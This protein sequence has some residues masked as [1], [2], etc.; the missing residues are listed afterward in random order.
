MTLGLNSKHHSSS[1]FLRDEVDILIPVRG[2]APW[3]SDCILSILNQTYENFKIYLIID[4]SAPNLEEVIS[5]V[6][7]KNLNKIKILTSPGKGISEALNHGIKNSYNEVIFR[8]DS[9]DTMEQSRIQEQLA[10]LNKFPDVGILGSQAHICNENLTIKSIT[11]LPTKH[12]EIIRTFK[13]SNSMIHPSVAIRRHILFKVGLYDKKADGYE[14]LELWLRLSKLT[15]FAN[16][17]KPLTNYRIHSGQKTFGQ[18]K[19]FIDKFVEAH[20]MNIEW[21]ERKRLLTAKKTLHPVS[22]KKR[23]NLN[24]IR[25]SREVIYHAKIKQNRFIFLTKAIKL[26]VTRPHLMV[27]ITKYALLNKNKNVK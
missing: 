11:H 7:I 23:Y 19:V 27:K 8:I 1:K 18:E 17:N 26:S 24:S 20:R 5:T 13:F 25:L 3:L 12:N 15:K 14:D 2:F 21:Q 9:D 16:L 22:L 4:E 6:E 10:Y